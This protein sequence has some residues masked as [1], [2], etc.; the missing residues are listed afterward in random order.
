[1]NFWG[2]K[3][4][5]EK[6]VFW[7]DADIFVFPSMNEAFG[8]VAVEAMEYGIPVIASNEGGIPEVVENG[9]NGLLVEKNNPISL[10]EAIIKLID[11]TSLRIQMGQNGRKKFEERFTEEQFEKTMIDCLKQCIVSKL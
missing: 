8:L 1:M 5:N 3:I 6:N 11:N 10:A 4:G 7:Q 2:R 9:V